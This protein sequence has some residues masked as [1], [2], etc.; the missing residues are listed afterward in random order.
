[1]R[2]RIAGIIESPRAFTSSVLKAAPAF[3]VGATKFTREKEPT[4]SSNQP[5]RNTEPGY[6][7]FCFCC[8]TL[9]NT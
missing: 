3:V 7:C 6:S 4:M 9:G 1:V 8:S 2:E 5:E